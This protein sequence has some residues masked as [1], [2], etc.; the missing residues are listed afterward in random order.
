MTIWRWIRADV[1][2]AIHDRQIAEHGGLD[3]IRDLG[4]VESALARPLNLANYGEPDGAG[5]AAA[6]AFGLARN[7]GFSDGNKRTA[8]IAARLF[9][10]DNG[11]QL[12]FD[13]A[14]AVKT[15]EAVA[16]G[17]MAEGALAEWLRQR[18]SKG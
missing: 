4:A 2:F 14:E 10:A 9:L 15:M 13:P 17:T 7:H 11:F 8:W 3:G 6:Y 16:A 1:L 12:T 5:L 18:M